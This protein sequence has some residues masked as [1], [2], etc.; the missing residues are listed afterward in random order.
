MLSGWIRGWREFFRCKGCNLFEPVG[1]WSHFSRN[2]LDLPGSVWVLGEARRLW[3]RPNV[4]RTQ[5]EGALENNSI[6]KIERIIRMFAG[7]VI[8][9]SLAL[10]HYHSAHWLWVT[11]FVGFNLFQSA[12][13]NFC[14]LEIVLKKA[15]V[16][17]PGAGC[18]DA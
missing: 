2:L 5:V 11:A 17:C 18:S 12:F 7:V 3:K 4:T 13:T 16:G 1:G 15:G 8:L 10:S 9:G 14:P 6:M